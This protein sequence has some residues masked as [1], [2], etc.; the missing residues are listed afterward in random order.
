MLLAMDNT[1]LSTGMFGIGEL[2]LS[3]IQ[4]GPVPALKIPLV[5]NITPA[6]GIAPATFARNST[7]TYIDANGVLQTAGID[8]PRFQN[9]RYLVESAATNIF[10]QSGT[11]ATQTITVVSGST[12]TVQCWGTG[13]ITLSGA[14]SGVVVE[15]IPV[16]FTASSTSLLCTKSG[17]VNR[18][19]VETGTKETSYIPTT[20]VPMYRV[21]DALHYNVGDVITQ[22][23]GSLYCEGVVKLRGLNQRFLNLSDGSTANRLYITLLSNATLAAYVVSA[24]TVQASISF[25]VPTEGDLVKCLLTYKDNNISFYVNGVAVGTD[26]TCQIPIVLNKL[27]A[28]CSHDSA[29]QLGNEVGNIKCFKEFLTPAPA[30]K[31]TTL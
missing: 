3:P 30:I 11:P 20:T 28:G 6:R 21:A 26:I 31:L 13:N 16:T 19:Q 24:G 17:I 15:G 7:A 4:S 10:L 8:I 9:G 14:G 2:N 22:G 12:Y 27:S 1:K 25:G 23:Q 5:S 29:L 18:A